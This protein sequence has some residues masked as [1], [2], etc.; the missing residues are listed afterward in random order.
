MS[1][2]LQQFLPALLEIRE[3]PPNPI[4]RYL[5]AA[6]SAFAV[7][8]VAWSCVGKVD[9]V[10]AAQG[11]IIP[12]SRVKQVQPLLRGVVKRNSCAGRPAGERR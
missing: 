2:S 8:A 5:L 11:Q 7:I 6:I 10:S 3:A 1:S 12:S 9:V 4:A